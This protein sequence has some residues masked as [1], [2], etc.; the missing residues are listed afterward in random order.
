MRDARDFYLASQ[1][2]GRNNL[3]ETR[4]RD[5]LY[6]TLG[7]QILN[8]WRIKLHTLRN[9]ILRERDPT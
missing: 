7:I 1:F 8:E 3:R 2:W 5:T 9:E 6:G 4:S